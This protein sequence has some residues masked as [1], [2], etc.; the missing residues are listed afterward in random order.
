MKLTKFMKLN[1]H[2]HVVSLIILTETDQVNLI[3][4]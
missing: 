3:R 2:Y 4:I 1:I